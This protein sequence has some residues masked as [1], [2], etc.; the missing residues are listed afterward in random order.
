[1]TD[2]SKRRSLKREIGPLYLTQDINIS[3]ESSTTDNYTAS[4]LG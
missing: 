3:R 1:M 2:S 4:R